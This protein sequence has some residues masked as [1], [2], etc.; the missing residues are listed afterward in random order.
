V[1]FCQK[2]LEPPLEWP[3]EMRTFQYFY[4]TMRAF[5]TAKSKVKNA[6]LR[7][8]YSQEKNGGYFA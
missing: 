4:E 6:T 7:K 8:G 2:Y 1:N 3:Q 5:Y